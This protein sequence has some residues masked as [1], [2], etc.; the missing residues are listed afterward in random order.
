MTPTPEE[1]RELIA[2]MK[3]EVRA[4]QSAALECPKSTHA[5]EAKERFQTASLLEQYV[6]P[7]V[8]MTETL[9]HGVYVHRRLDGKTYTV[10]H[11]YVGAPQISHDAES[12]GE[13]LTA[14]MNSMSQEEGK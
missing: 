13:A 6:L 9:E 2:S 8:V 4:L 7:L 1:V 5:D 10:V 11:Q 12:I 14:A 3:D